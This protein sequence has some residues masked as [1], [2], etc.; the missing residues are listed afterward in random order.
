MIEAKFVTRE[1]LQAMREE[2]VTQIIDVIDGKPAAVNI[3]A[4]LEVLML[5][6]VDF[7]MEQNKLI[8]LVSGTAMQYYHAERKDEVLQ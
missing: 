2:M 7:G 1:E 6:A 5:V 4:L 8:D 3:T